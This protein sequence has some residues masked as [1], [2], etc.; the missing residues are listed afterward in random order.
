MATQ[1]IPEDIILA[2]IHGFETRIAEL[3]AMLPENETTPE[4]ANEATAEPKGPRKR[5]KFSAEA[6]KRMREAQRARWEKIRGGATAA[7]P[8]QNAPRKKRKM[9][10][11]GRA[12]I[13]EA[14]RKRW[15][16]FRASKAQGGKKA[17]RKGAAKKV[18]TTQTAA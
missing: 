6:R 4:P 11:E 13:A 18:T 17:G 16:A 2:A 10:A 8:V 7:A 14:T 1:K 15:A 3:R 9:S 12:K 5:R